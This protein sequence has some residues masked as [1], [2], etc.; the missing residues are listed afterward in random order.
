M[1]HQ[2]ASINC[3]LPLDWIHLSSQPALPKLG[4][5]TTQQVWSDYG[6]VDNPYHQYF[7]ILSGYFHQRYIEMDPVL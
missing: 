1:W 3:A 2:V 7:Q 4:A 5:F 6:D